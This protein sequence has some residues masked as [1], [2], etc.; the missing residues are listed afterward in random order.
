MSIGIEETQVDFQAAV[1]GDSLSYVH[2]YEIQVNIFGSDASGS[3]VFNGICDPNPCENG[4]TCQIGFGNRLSCQC[5]GGYIGK[6]MFQIIYLN[7]IFWT[8]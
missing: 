5:P 7:F 6:M 1:V 4:G 8:I 2:F 3:E